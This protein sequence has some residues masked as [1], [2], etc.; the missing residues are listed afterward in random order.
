MIDKI[1]SFLW[2]PV[3]EPEENLGLVLG[4]VPEQRYMG[5]FIFIPEVVLK[6]N[7]EPRSYVFSFPVK[8]VSNIIEH[9]I[10]KDLF[11]QVLKKAYDVTVDKYGNILG[12]W[13][14]TPG[15]DYIK[16]YGE[17]GTYGKYSQKELENLV[18]STPDLDDFNIIYE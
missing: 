17:S 12:G 14:N 15:K 1:P 5:K 2:C 6:E 4:K 11:P 3:E 13:V 18:L 8:S 16:F 10:M 9:S 7:S